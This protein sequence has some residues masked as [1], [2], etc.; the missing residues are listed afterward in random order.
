MTNRPFL[1]FRLLVAALGFASCL[2]AALVDMSPP[3]QDVQAEYTGF[4]MVCRVFDPAQ[5]EWIEDRTP[6]GIVL[7]ALNR[8]GVVAW[9]SGNA[10]N[11]RTYDP[12]LTNWVRLT[13]PAPTAQDLR[14]HRGFTAWSSGNQVHYHVYEPATGQFYSESVAS[15][16]F[17]LR[18]SDGVVSWTSGGAVFLRTFDPARRRWEGLNVA[19]GQTFDLSSTNGIVAWSNGNV[20]RT[21]VYDALRSRWM[22][23][24]AA[25]GAP[26]GQLWNDSGLVVWSTGAILWTR[27]FNPASGQWIPGQVVSPSG[28]VLP[29]GITNATAFW[30][31]GFTLRRLG[32]DWYKTAWSTNVTLALPVFAVSTNA[33]KPPLSVRFT[34][35]SVGATAQSWNFGDSSAPSL[36]RSPSHVFTN[37][38]R[39]PVTL[40]LAGFGTNTVFRT[41]ILT[42]LEAPTGSVVINDGATSTTNR[43][44]TLTLAATDNS[45]SVP[46]MRLSNDGS[47]WQDWEPFAPTKAWQLEPGVTTRTVHAQFEDPFGNRSAVL[48][49]SIFLDTTPPPNAQFAVTTTNVLEQ[50]RTFTFAV[51]LDHPMSSRAVRVDYATVDGTATAGSDYVAAS[52]TLIYPAGVTTQFVSVQILDDTL[53]ELDETFSIELLNPVDVV[54]GDPLVI[55][56]VDNDLATVRFSADRFTAGEGDGAGLLD[57]ILSAPS[58]QTV[59]VGF[60]ATN[61]TAVAGVDFVPV[62]GL[63]TFLPGQTTQIISVPILDDL[64]DEFTE[65]VLVRL[66]NATNASLGLPSTAVLEILDNDPPTVNFAAAEYHAEEA[67]GS[68]PIAVTLTKPYAQTVLVDYATQGGTAVPGKDYVVASGTLIFSPGQTN[69]VFHVTLLPNPAAGSGVTVGLQLS[70][71]VNVLPGPRI[72]ATLLIADAD[73]LTL[74]ALGFDDL[75]GFHLQITGPP[76]QRVR[77]ETA[78]DLGPSPVWEVLGTLD[79]PTG[80]VEFSDPA[81][82]GQV[83]RYYR[84]QAVP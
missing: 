16:T 44:V 3:L 31:D 24:D 25:T 71:F 75:G 84:A 22:G 77:V 29:T 32:Y 15:S 70:D 1:C 60:A 46:Q 79:N 23:D 50:T 11:L 76:G 45:G 28:T 41:N 57:V 26:L 67:A 18:C 43:N 2:R 58:G 49:D 4:E 7:E 80:T 8:N 56:I 48:T 9:S 33:G 74:T 21:R 38:G 34:D 17:D 61:G 83:R 39:F 5:N 55:T 13:I 19:S 52:G 14:S 12:S 64:E 20:V 65:T 10:F 53:V 73:A 36:Q 51:T 72:H 40:T 78:S 54:P 47:N 63:L 6:A 27:L 37:L 68:A 42:D 30:S 59:T 66:E 62:T 35:L 69:R 81:A 82:T